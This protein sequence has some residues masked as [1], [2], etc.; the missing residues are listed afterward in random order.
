MSLR[1]YQVTLK[2][3]APSQFVDEDNVIK[4]WK[5]ARKN[6]DE[7]FEVASGIFLT[8]SILCVL[9]NLK[10]DRMVEKYLKDRKAI[11]DTGTGLHLPSDI[12]VMNTN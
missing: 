9:D 1:Q 3:G 6:G 12:D 5:E 8:D 4:K 7:Y 2:Q 11:V 10:N